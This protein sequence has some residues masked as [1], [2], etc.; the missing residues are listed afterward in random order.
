VFIA[1]FAFPLILIVGV[2]LLVLAGT[3]DVGEL[4]EHPAALYLAFMTL[5]GVLLL[6]FA[7]FLTTHGLTHL[8]GGSVN[9]DSDVS[10]VVVGVIGGAVAA[11]VLWFHLPK[12][13]ATAGTRIYTHV[14]YTV[15]VAAV[16]TGLAAAA[17]TLYAIY[18]MVAPDTA[19]FDV[20]TDGLRSFIAS[21]VL[22]VTAGLVFWQAWQRSTE[23]APASE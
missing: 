11:A 9:H 4:R 14:L 18:G 19:G 10:Q 23:A 8:M 22:A 16:L 12:L 21:A 17:S 7:T 6:L 3:N 1:L 13:H 15:C 5:T 20:F 2:V